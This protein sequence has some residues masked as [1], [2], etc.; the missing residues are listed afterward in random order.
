MY[1]GGG[2]TRGMIDIRDT[3]ECIRLA[4][5]NPADHGEFRVFNQM[6]EW[7]SVLQIAETVADL[8][9][10]EVKI[11]YLSNPRGDIEEH[12]YNVQRTV[13]WSEAAFAVGNAAV[14]A[15][16]HRRPV[17]AP[18]RRPGDA[19]DRA[20]A[21]RSAGTALSAEKD[22]ATADLAHKGFGRTFLHAQ[23]RNGRVRARTEA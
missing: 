19:A 4:V 13:I 18:R 3:A 17:E 20:V 5:E 2:Q 22:I 12:S 8:H 9:P 7:M 6:T 23:C 14:L 11:D 10:N 21:R 1:G 15:L 16:R